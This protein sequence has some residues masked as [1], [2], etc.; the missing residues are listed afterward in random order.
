M[1]RMC[2]INKIKKKQK[3]TQIQV[4]N[5]NW[6][7]VKAKR[8]KRIRE[9]KRKKKI[10]KYT[11]KKKENILHVSWIGNCIF[12][13]SRLVSLCVRVLKTLHRNAITHLELLFSAY[14]RERV[15]FFSS[16]SPLR[17]SDF[18]RVATKWGMREQERIHV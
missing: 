1:L 2:I 6:M 17:I 11:V 10:D 9:K 15:I 4:Q 18:T 16:S 7:T 8:S 5:W 14:R 3:I 12:W 13:N